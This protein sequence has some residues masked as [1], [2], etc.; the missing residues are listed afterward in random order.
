MLVEDLNPELTQPIRGA[1]TIPVAAFQDGDTCA[2]SAN[3]DLRE[4]LAAEVTRLSSMTVR[5]AAGLAAGR[6]LADAY[7]ALLHRLN[8][9]A[10]VPVR[11]QTLFWLV[12]EARIARETLAASAGSSQSLR[13][14]TSVTQDVQAEIAKQDDVMGPPGLEPRAKVTVTLRS[15]TGAPVQPLRV[16]YTLAGLVQDGTTMPDATR[17]FMKVGETVSELLP[18][19]DYKIWAAPEGE[20]RRV[21]TGVVDVRA[22]ARNDGD[23]VSVTL[24]VK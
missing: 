6:E 1:V 23:E 5:D 17:P 12:T 11:R 2:I 10:A 22:R 21:L 18:I 19:K 9:D 3:V 24:L 14:L 13:L 4:A 15:Q 20:P 7:E 16:Y 8:D